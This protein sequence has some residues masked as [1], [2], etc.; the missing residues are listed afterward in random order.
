MIKGM[1]PRSP[2]LEAG[3]PSFTAAV[4]TPSSPTGTES[5]GKQPGR[6]PCPPPTYRV[7][8]TIFESGERLPTLLGADDLPVPVP[9]RYALLRL[10][11]VAQRSTIEDHLRTIAGAYEWATRRRLDI[12]D[13]MF[14]GNGL[15]SDEIRALVDSLRLTR[16]TARRVAGLTLYEASDVTIVAPDTHEK[17]FLQLREFLLW[18]AEG[19]LHSHDI[20]DPIYA[21]IKERFNSMRRVL[22]SFNFPKSD[23]SDREG[24]S[25]EQQRRLFEVV[26]PE[27]RWNPFNAPVRV[28]NYL[29][30]VI[31]FLFGFRRGES[32][33]IKLEDTNIRGTRY[34]TIKL[35]RR[36]DDPDERRLAP[37][38]VKTN[39]REVP[40]DQRLAKLL[41]E[42]I[43]IHR[44]LFVGSDNSPYLL[45]SSR[46][47]ALS[48]RQVNRIFEQICKRFPEFSGLLVPHVLRHTYNDG[49]S[50]AARLL[51]IDKDEEKT[52]RNY[53]NGWSRDSD[54]GD[55]YRQRYIRESASELCL[56]HQRAIFGKIS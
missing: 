11:P 16:P 30:I 53:L 34:P 31:L 43:L 46:E 45:M 25:E 5:E 21:Q 6:R 47:Q 54:Q 48:L 26:H 51:K 49:I 40:I 4:P 37:P 9:N 20:R 41:N 12:E 35:F 55:A 15:S 32:L 39:G 2:A 52:L 24:L 29:V 50:T 56:E 13:R 10:R 7:V 3:R 38:A 22:Y 23:P 44:P 27:Y 8:E 14:S 1:C 17:R 36:P 42:F 19:C 33:K 18:L 28:R